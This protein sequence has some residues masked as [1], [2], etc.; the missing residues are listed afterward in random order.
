M[1]IGSHLR[2]RPLNAKHV[3][4]IS[5]TKMARKMTILARLPRLNK[6]LQRKANQLKVSQSR[7]KP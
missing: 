5:L 7:T 2:T 3:R 1:S 6:Q 4:R